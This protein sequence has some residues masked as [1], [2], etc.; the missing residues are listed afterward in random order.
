MSGGI[1][2][3]AVDV[4]SGKPAVGMQVTLR[5]LSPDPRTVASGIIAEDGTFPGRHV[6]GEGCCPGAYEVVFQFDSFYICSN[7][8][9]GFLRDVPF[10][11]FVRDDDGHV[12]LPIKFSPWGYALFRGR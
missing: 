5:R 2:I 4:V 9:P 7:D 12:H 10:R 6:T 8:A 11:F 3:H 1:S